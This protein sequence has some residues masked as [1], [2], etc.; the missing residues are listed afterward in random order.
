[1]L[2][3]EQERY[4]E[5]GPYR[6]KD[7]HSRAS[8]KRGY[9]RRITYIMRLIRAF[10]V[11]NAEQVSANALLFFP[12]PNDLIYDRNKFLLAY[13]V[14]VKIYI[15]ITRM[16]HFRSG[17]LWNQTGKGQ[18][19]CQFA[20]GDEQ[21]STPSGKAD[22]GLPSEADKIP[23]KTREKKTTL[24]DGTRKGKA[25]KMATNLHPPQFSEEMRSQLKGYDEFNLK[26]AVK[27]TT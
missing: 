16:V 20:I 24:R 22:M 27:Q 1:M 7:A 11:C 17:L 3:Q 13:M 10:V 2:H 25:L 26:C 18:H 5:N 15:S 14:F 23:L 21:F 8:H 19:F 12:A 9:S 4:F 6:Q